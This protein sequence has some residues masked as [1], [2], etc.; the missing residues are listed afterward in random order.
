MKPE[1]RSAAG[2]IGIGIALLLA[3]LLVPHAATAA[4]KTVIKIGTLIPEG[5]TWVKNL[6]A[7]NETITAAT[8]GRVRLKIY[9]GG[10]LGDENDMLRKMLSGQIQ[11]SVLTASGMGILN[12]D[13]QVLQVPFLLKSYDEVDH[14]LAG[15]Q[16]YLQ[17]G[18]DAKGYV[19]LGW[20]EG[21]FVRLMSMVPASTLEEL[22]SAKVWIWQDAPMAAIIFEEAGLAGIPLSATDV[23]MGLQ[24]GLVDV[25]YAPPAGAIALQWFTKIKYLNE[26]P[27][28]YTVGGI[29][30]QKKVFQRLSPEDQAVVKENFHT[31]MDQLKHNVRRENKE[32]LEVMA[33]SGVKIVNSPEEEIV[34]FNALSQRAVERYVKERFSQEALD[35]VRSLLDQYR[36]AKP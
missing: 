11:G 9:A 10:V 7:L 22:R 26:L 23:L 19:L 21:G 6:K 32:A 5:S 8:D 18:L 28:T 16:D 20:S 3:L 13:M 4:P 2:K 35:K 31:Y 25:V 27:L 36:K 24:T 29:V 17:Q 1:K 14:L 33:Q 12:R 30:V 15:M 34:K